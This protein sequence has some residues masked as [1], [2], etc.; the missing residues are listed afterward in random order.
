MYKLLILIVLTIFVAG[1]SLPEPIFDNFE[2]K[3]VYSVDSPL[4]SPNPEDS[5][6]YQIVY[7]KDSMLR[8][9][10]YTPIGKQIYIKHIPRNRAYILMDLGPKKVA[11]Q[12]IPDTS[13]AS[14]Y[15]FDY[16]MGSKKMAERKA[17][18]IS[19]TDTSHDTTMVMNYL[20]EI[21][22]K[23]SN[24]IKGIPGLPAK[25]KLESNGMWITY[26]LKSIEKQSMDID[27]FGIPSDYEIISLDSFIDLIKK[28]DQSN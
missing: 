3:F 20:P 28:Q 6:N 23:Y 2:G 17:K 9:D 12:T 4:N 8:I 16:K 15:I 25:Y 18:N 13:K 27:Y 1:C 24:A 26:E 21:S 14:K 19:V 11:I 10:S 7:A 5:I 22:P